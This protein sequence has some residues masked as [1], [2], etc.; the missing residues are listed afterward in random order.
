M[1][2]VRSQ[3][4]VNRIPNDCTPEAGSVLV[5]AQRKQERLTAGCQ[6]HRAGIQEAGTAQ[7][8]PVLRPATGPTL[9]HGAMKGECREDSQS[10]PKKYLSVQWGGSRRV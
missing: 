4:A 10:P 2:L 7:S 8:L 1:A 9:A 5:L 6:R 3:E